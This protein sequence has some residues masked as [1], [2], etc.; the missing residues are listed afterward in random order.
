[1]GGPKYERISSGEDERAPAWTTKRAVV[2]LAACSAFAAYTAPHATKVAAVQSLYKVGHALESSAAAT[3]GTLLAADVAAVE[4]C[5]ACECDELESLGVL[6]ADA[7]GATESPTA[8]DYWE[9]FWTD[10]EFGSELDDS[11]VWW[12][13]E[14]LE[15]VRA[16]VLV[17]TFGDS[18]GIDID[19]NSTSIFFTVDGCIGRVEPDG[20]DLK[21]VF[22]YDVD[23]DPGSQMEGL[24]L[25]EYD[26][27]MYWV[28]K[29]RNTLYGA[30][31]EGNDGDYWV[32]SESF[33]EPID[34]AVDERAAALYVVDNTGIYKMDQDGSDLTLV[35]SEADAGLANFGGLDVDATNRQLFFAAANQIYVADIF[36]PAASYAAVYQSLKSPM[37]VAV[38]PEENLLFFI[39]DTGV[40]R[41]DLEGSSDKT[42]VAEIQDARFCAV[43]S[44][45]APTPAPT[46]VPTSRPSLE[47]TSAP[48]FPPTPVP[49]PS[50]TSAPSP[51]PTPEPSFMPTSEPT[52][53]PTTYPSFA[54]S[55]APTTSPT[56]LPTRHPSPA[57]TGAP[58]YAP[59]PGAVLAKTFEQR[60]GAIHRRRA[61]EGVLPR[62]T[63][64]AQPQKARRTK[65]AASNDATAAES[66]SACAHLAT[67]NSSRTAP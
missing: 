11:Y 37:G 57:P 17:D 54:P 67:Q 23:D 6:A 32:V 49:V 10:G 12:T 21:E 48:S 14:E 27:K 40:Y 4:D 33:D 56:P 26:N 30:E 55:S 1:M 2:A 53:L 5:A 16:N 59:S 45:S 46:P 44:E 22:C 39:D 25:Y 47:P 51:Q 50:P 36:D 28:D 58:S 29:K 65:R 24:A 8:M 15:G 19:S 66:P 35:L 62:R 41:G 9:L 64:S 3:D 52:F 20:L 7:G 60:R 43:L 38:S 34:V 18:R 61:A 42:F 31:L 63:G 13:N